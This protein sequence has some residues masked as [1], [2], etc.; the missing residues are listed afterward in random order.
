MTKADLT[1]ELHDKNGLSRAESV[2]MVELIIETI[3]ANLA[4]GKTVKIAGFGTF[5]VRKKGERKGRIIKT[6]EEIT[7]T[8]R[9]V[10]TFRASNQFKNM[11]EKV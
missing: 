4:E 6:G 3:K 5:T 8:P 1:K 7:I 2:H 10:V 9:K 11:V